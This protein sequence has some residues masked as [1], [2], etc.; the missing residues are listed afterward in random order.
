MMASSSAP[1]PKR[2]D[3]AVLEP[4]LGLQRL[5]RRAPE[6]DHA[7]V[8]PALD[9]LAVGAAERRDGAVHALHVAAPAGLDEDLGVLDALG[10]A[11]LLGTTAAESTAGAP[12]SIAGGRRSPGHG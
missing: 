10:M 2:L 8:A 12:S 9:D 7:G 3:G 6:G 1:Q 11:L 5:G 4:R